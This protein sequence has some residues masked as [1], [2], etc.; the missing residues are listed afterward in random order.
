MLP[1]NCKEELEEFDGTLGTDVSFYLTKM[2]WNLECLSGTGITCLFLREEVYVL[3]LLNNVIFI[4]F[5]IG[6]ILK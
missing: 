5:G 6:K 3:V 1:I 4:Y 2:K